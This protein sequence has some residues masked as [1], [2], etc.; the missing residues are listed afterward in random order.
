MHLYKSLTKISEPLFNYL[1]KA[2]L[3]KGKEHA[4]RFTERK[5]VA[6]YA[7]PQGQLVWFHAASVG[8]SQSALILINEI[9]RDYPGLH[10]L[11]TTGT[12]TSSELMKKNLPEGVIHQFY[13]LDHPKW[14][15]SF[16]EHWQPNFV[17]W[18]ESELWPNMLSSLKERKITSILLNARLSKRSYKRWSYMPKA[19][20]NMITTFDL[21]LCQTDTDALYYA[22]LGAQNIH[23]TDNLKYSAAPLSYNAEDYKAIRNALMG[24]EVCL[25]ASTHKGE[26][27]IAKNVH[28]KLKHKHPNLITIIVPRHPERSS[29]IQDSLS[30]EDVEIQ[31]RSMSNSE[32]NYNTDIYIADTLGELGLFYRV[33]PFA[34]IGR[35]LSDDGGG[36]HNP[37]EAAQL[38]CAVL[39]GGNIQN[40]QD[41]FD[42][43]DAREAAI[44]VRDEY[45]LYEKIENFLSNAPELQKYQENAFAFSAS[46]NKVLERVSEHLTPYLKQLTL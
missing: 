29:Q 46:K 40:L 44:S 20:K 26:E 32:P 28:L 39:H 6:S 30:G 5:G 38:N 7:R 43:M 8:E 34:L 25:Y 31:S 12:L 21:I 11:V 1:L 42:E 14:V 23:V 10:I 35:S 18:M 9:K 4:E 36:G 41:I 16:L 45:E 2:R 22:K 15:A 3:K 24:R 19:F 33:S 37:I 13:P 27:E 17:F